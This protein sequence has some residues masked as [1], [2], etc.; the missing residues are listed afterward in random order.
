[1]VAY[2][3]TAAG[4]LAPA[5]VSPL[6]E[7]IRHE[8]Q[9]ALY[10]ATIADL[11]IQ[12]QERGWQRLGEGITAEFSRDEIGVIVAE[13]RAAYL[14]NSLVNR[15]VEIV[16]LYVFGQD[17]SINA[18]D[19]SVQ[20]VVDRFWEDN[21]ATLTGQQAS[22]ALDVE[23]TV[24]GN[25]F[26]ALF[27]D[28]VTGSVKVRPIPVEE[29]REVVCNPEDRY[30]PWYYRR[31]WEQ[32]RPDGTPEPREAF[33]PDW[34]HNPTDRPESVQ[35]DG[36]DVP[37]VWA[38]PVCRVK[39]GAFPHWKWGVPEV[40]ASLDWVRAYTRMLENDATRSAALARW[41]WS[42]K[43]DSTAE[44]TAIKA[45]IG[46]T[47]GNGVSETN[48]PP[49]AGSV[50]IGKNKPEPIDISRAILPPD[51]SRPV[52]LMAAAALGIPDH[53]FDADVGNHATA[54]T[55]DRPTELRIAERRQLWHDTLTDLLQWAI[56]RDL[57]AV[58]GLLT[59]T[60]DDE[61]RKAEVSQPDILEPDI[62]ARVDA[63]VKAA[64]LGGPA[65][66]G[67]LPAETVSRLLLSALGVE[68]I[69][70]E[71]A[72]LADEE[73]EERAEMAAQIAQRTGPPDDDE[74]REAFVA[75]MRE[76]REA[77]TR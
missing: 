75:T 21:R 22:R 68:D 73:R 76:V 13:A 64:T 67:T 42:I 26:L 56:D 45:R 54:K 59:F 17:V 47:L 5:N 19:E 15:A 57:A 63:V 70:G 48:P 4:I 44:T 38:A 30:E 33:Y 34:R 35:V 12:L 9:A 50:A 66:A 32:R 31:R 39:V 60:P 11:R 2:H 53:F 16:A 77:L 7:G 40:Y 6:N 28:P 20:A 74:E 37:V 24:T 36:K 8:L 14:K 10:E 29:V 43:S 18:P 27:A 3:E 62:Q 52:R 51:H 46:T 25:L 49:T 69:D 58:R 41:A 1:M 55:L 23:L 71:L 65:A 61:A 72:K